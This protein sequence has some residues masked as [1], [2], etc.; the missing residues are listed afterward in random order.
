[1]SGE[2]LIRLAAIIGRPVVHSLSPLIHGYW[3]REH[4][5]RGAYLPFEVEKTDIAAAIRGLAA[6]GFVEA[7]VTIPFKEAAARLVD[8]LCPAAVRTGAVNLISRT[9]DGRLIGDNT[10]GA[11]FIDSLRAADVDLA[12]LDGPIV[13]IGAGGAARGIAGALLAETDAVLRLVNRGRER[14][15]LLAAALEPKR[16]EVFGLDNLRAAVDG[17]ALLINASALGMRGMPPLS[18]PFGAL[19]RGAVVADIVYAPAR[20]AFL[21]AAEEAGFRTV[22]G[23]EMLLCQAR[24]AFERWFGLRPEISPGLRRRCADYLESGG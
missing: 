15:A 8:E 23:L 2:E 22:C 4:R 17:A 6:L 12:V 20:T 10:D 21:V 14:A 18:A 16:I 19:P 24:P 11:G 5:I 7:N 1:M 13:I 9:A 3:L